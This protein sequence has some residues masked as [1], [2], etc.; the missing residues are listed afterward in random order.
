MYTLDSM[1]S[2]KV[3]SLPASLSPCLPLPASF[4]FPFFLSV[5]VSLSISSLS[6]L[7]SLARSPSLSRSLSLSSLFLALFHSL[8]L[9]LTCTLLAAALPHPRSLFFLLSRLSSFSSPRSQVV[10]DLNGRGEVSPA[11]SYAISGT[12]IAA[13]G[14]AYARTMRSPGLI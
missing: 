13:A 1:P 12:I 3:L 5:S 10:G 14:S 9:S 6:R 2:T 8:S 7:P 4:C 11:I